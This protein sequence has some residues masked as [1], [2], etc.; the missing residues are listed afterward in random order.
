MHH[1]PLVKEIL[2]TRTEIS[3]C[4]KQLAKEIDNYYRNQN[5][6]EN[7]IICIGLLKGCVPF[8]SEFLNHF[9][10]ECEIDYI[11]VSS[12]M[13]TTNAMCLPRIISDLNTD[14]KDRHVLIFEDVIDSGLTLEFIKQNF[15]VRGATDI[16]ILTLI[17]KP[18][19]RKISLKPDWF[20]FEVDD[21]F[22]IG[23]GLDYQERLRNLPYVASCD[24]EKLLTWKWKK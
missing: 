24:T 4:S 2:Y 17:N 11:T 7:T 21:E 19:K 23:F 1:H 6:K 3:N 9:E 8:M 13:G 12:Y 5:V 22:L 18:K 20:C 16:K 15:E 10:Y 14:L